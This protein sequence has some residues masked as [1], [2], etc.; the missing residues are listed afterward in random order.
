M[1]TSTRGASSR[2]CPWWCRLRGVLS[3][4]MGTSAHISYKLTYQ[5]LYFMPEGQFYALAIIDMYRLCPHRGWA[6]ICGIAGELAR[7][8]YPEGWSSEL[9][10]ELKLVHGFPSIGIRDTHIGIRQIDYQ[11][12]MKLSQKSDEV[13]KMPIRQ[14]NLQNNAYFATIWRLFKDNWCFR[15]LHLVKS[16]PFL[17]LIHPFATFVHVFYHKLHNCSRGNVPR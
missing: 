13:R 15:N 8:G 4:R 9:N 3:W 11:C 14:I 7:W 6:S 2:P 12:V 17:M 10:W 16:F 5:S 1:Q